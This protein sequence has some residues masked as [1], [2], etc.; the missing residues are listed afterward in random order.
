MKILIL[1]ASLLLLPQTEQIDGVTVEKIKKPKKELRFSVVVPAKLDD[2]WD[3]FTT[4]EG[5]RTWLWSDVRVD[6]RA[7]GDWLVLFPGGKTGGGTIVSFAPKSKIT[8]RAMA[9][10][11]YPTVRRERTTAVFL[12]ERASASTTKVS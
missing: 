5:L 6:L 12:F 7:G 9:P 4:N 3:A 2:V 11:A 8:M 1:F 10:E